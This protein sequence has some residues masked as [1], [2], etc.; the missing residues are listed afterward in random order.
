M[1][2]QTARILI[3]LMTGKLPD[4]QQVLLRSELNIRGS[5]GPAKVSNQPALRI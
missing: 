3:S 4:P 2:Y 5:T 1:G